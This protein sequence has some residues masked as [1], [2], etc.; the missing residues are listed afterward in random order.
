MMKT[1]NSSLQTR[2][3]DNRWSYDKTRK[4]TI[5]FVVFMLLFSM[6]TT[7]FI[8][9]GKKSPAMQ[10]R[11]QA[12][13][14]EMLPSVRSQEWAA[15]QGYGEV[16]QKLTAFIQHEMAD[17]KIPGLTIS[18][19]DGKDIVWARGFGRTDTTQRLLATP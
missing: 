16:A 6:G 2:Y 17:K 8:Y 5:G 12:L 18:L 7:L 1:G 9:L 3:T 14:Q 4:Y 19:A 11:L 10:S 13:S 15:R